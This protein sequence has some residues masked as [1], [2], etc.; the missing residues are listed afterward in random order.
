MPANQGQKYFESNTNNHQLSKSVIEAAK[1]FEQDLA[2]SSQEEVQF[3]T[4]YTSKRQPNA[5]AQ[6][7]VLD[8]SAPAVDT[9]QGQV[10]DQISLMGKRSNHKKNRNTHCHLQ[11]TF[12]QVNM[13]ADLSQHLATMRD[14]FN[15]NLISPQH[16]KR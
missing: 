2:S 16:K 4:P 9:N 15:A 13:N 3:G 12:H 8:A 10:L 6:I 1:E 7:Q 5:S 11:N 14:R